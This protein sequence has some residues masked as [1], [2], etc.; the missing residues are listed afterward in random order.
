MGSCCCKKKICTM[1]IDTMKTKKNTTGTLKVDKM[2]I[3][4]LKIGKMIT[5]SKTSQWPSIFIAPADVTSLNQIVQDADFSRIVSKSIKMK[6]SA[7]TL[8][9]SD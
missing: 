5:D 4:E 9:F 1:Q 3:R 6:G 2:E 8:S 7:S